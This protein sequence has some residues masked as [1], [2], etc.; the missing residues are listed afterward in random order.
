MMAQAGVSI[1]QDDPESELIDKQ[2]TD[3]VVFLSSIK[4]AIEAKQ[5]R[6]SM[7]GD[8]ARIPSLSG[9]GRPGNP[10]TQIKD[11]NELWKL[12]RQKGK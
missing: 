2:T 8:P 5:Q 3:P 4:A 9:S 11:P 1:E 10:V 6:L 12:A 7:A